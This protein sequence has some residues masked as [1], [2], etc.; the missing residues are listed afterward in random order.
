MTELSAATV[1]V[2]RFGVHVELKLGGTD[3]AIR[4]FAAGGADGDED[5][6]RKVRDADG[7][8]RHGAWSFSEKRVL[9]MLLRSVGVATLCRSQPRL[10][11]ERARLLVVERSE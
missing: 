2:D 11:E 9:K 6:V 5:W 8:F 3:G 10:R 4:S 7:G 1:G